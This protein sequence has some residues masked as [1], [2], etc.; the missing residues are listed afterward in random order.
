[1][2]NC[3]KKMGKINWLLARISAI[4]ILIYLI[5]ISMVWLVDAPSNYI[6]WRIALLS[7]L[8][9]L[10]FVL[11]LGGIL[12]HAWIGVWTVLTDYV[13]C[14]FL[15]NLLHVSAFLMLIACFVWGLIIV[16]I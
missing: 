12:L 15:Q 3:C 7:P 10:S 5:L 14:K 11:C 6:A 8:M 2:S 16:S 1:M 4:F 9:R 13:T